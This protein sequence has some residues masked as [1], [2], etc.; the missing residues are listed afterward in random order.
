M[1]TDF[2]P[3]PTCPDCDRLHEPEVFCPR[4]VAANFLS[5]NEEN[6][7]KL[8]LADWD[9]L[10]IACFTIDLR[11]VLEDYLVDNLTAEG[12]LQQPH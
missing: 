9:A 2:K 5:P 4:R 6:T 11:T 10:R 12:K 3:L 1:L 8:T 7:K